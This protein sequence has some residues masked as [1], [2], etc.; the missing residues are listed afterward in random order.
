MIFTDY[1]DF[2][3]SLNEFLLSKLSYAY[4][5]IPIFANC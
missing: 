1:Y 4:V 2:I 5:A 3:E